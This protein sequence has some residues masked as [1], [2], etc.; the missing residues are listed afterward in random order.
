MNLIS[1]NTFVEQTMVLKGASP[2]ST[3][4]QLG[5]AMLILSIDGLTI[6]I[7]LH[8]QSGMKY[9]NISSTA[10]CCMVCEVNANFYFILTL[11]RLLHACI[12]DYLREVMCTTRRFLSPLIITILFSQLDSFVLLSAF[13]PSSFFGNLH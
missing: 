9:E 8:T 2:Y 13:L 3:P 6:F 11:F 4:T 10:N 7:N 5:G 12:I 1:F